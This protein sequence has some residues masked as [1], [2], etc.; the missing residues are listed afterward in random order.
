[1]STH[2]TDLFSDVRHHTGDCT[3][4]RAV[5]DEAAHQ[6]LCEEG[7]RL[8]ILAEATILKAH[9]NASTNSTSPIRTQ[10]AAMQNE[11]PTL[12]NGIPRVSWDTGNPEPLSVFITEDGAASL[13][14]VDSGLVLDVE[15][16]APGLVLVRARRVA[17]VGSRLPPMGPTDQTPGRFRRLATVIAFRSAVV[18]APLLLGLGLLYG[19]EPGPEIGKVVFAGAVLASC[20]AI[21][22]VERYSL[23]S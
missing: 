19:T 5:L 7:L 18:C 10:G 3:T 11:T 13:M 12:S 22:I 15:Q 1:M 6:H 17:P 21:D 23:L 14:V 20:V 16:P 9:S 2:P 8:L 4:C